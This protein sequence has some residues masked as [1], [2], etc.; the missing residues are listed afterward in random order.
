VEYTAVSIKKAKIK[1]HRFQIN[2]NLGMNMIEGCKG[3]IAIK[4]FT[5]SK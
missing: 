5:K 3:V 4:S 1:G 2:K